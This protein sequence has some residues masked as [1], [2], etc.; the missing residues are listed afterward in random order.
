MPAIAGLDT[1][2]GL[3]RVGGN[4]KLYL[5]LLRQFVDLQGRSVEHVTDALAARD[6]PL[7]ERLAHTLKGVAGNI[8]ATR[9]HSAAAVLE[10]AIRQRAAPGEVNSATQE[11]AAALAPLV[12]ELR[13]VLGSI[14]AAPPEPSLAVQADPARSREAA[15]RL[16]VLLSDLDPG[17][18]DFVEANHTLLQPLFAAAAWPEFESRVQNYAFADAQAQLERALKGTSA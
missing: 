7:A 9:V 8:G 2:D 14:A 10:S 13:A 4:R 6:A 3:S 1:E 17:A 15:A 5:K 16:V 12:T 18:A 11:V